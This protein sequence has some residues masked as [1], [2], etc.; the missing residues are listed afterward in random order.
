[1]ETYVPYMRNRSKTTNRRNV[2]RAN[3]LH[4]QHV[5]TGR[6]IQIKVNDDVHTVY[7]S[8]GTGKSEEKIFLCQKESNDQKRDRIKYKKV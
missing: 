8:K 2:R 7:S 3:V 1:M 6:E 4:E 5:V